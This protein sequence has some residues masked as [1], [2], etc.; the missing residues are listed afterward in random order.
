MTL[1]KAIEWLKHHADNT[2]MPGAR[3]AYRAILE[4]LG[5][6]CFIAGMMFF[7]GDVSLPLKKFYCT[8]VTAGSLWASHYSCR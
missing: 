2:P 1:D 4:A 7:C 5:E 3:E 8:S 6:L